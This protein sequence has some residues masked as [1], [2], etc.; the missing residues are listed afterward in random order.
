MAQTDFDWTDSAIARLRELW[1]EGHSTA[2]IGRRMGISKNAI[3]GK[4][5]RLRLKPRPSPVKALTREQRE[6]RDAEMGRRLAA[7]AARKA[8]LPN[9]TGDT[10]SPDAQAN[11][12]R[13]AADAER[14]KRRAVIPRGHNGNFVDVTMNARIE[15]RAKTVPQP[16]RPVPAPLPAHEPKPAS[17][18]PVGRVRP[19]AWI[20]GNT[21]KRDFRTCGEPVEPG[22]PYCLVHCKICYVNYQ[23]K[24][25]LDAGGNP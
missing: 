20:A 16:V 11:R 18:K 9:L 19:C 21:D 10:P 13:V 12:N 17:A 3:V 5:H 4:S 23:P 22:T 15:A 2:E 24:A 7:S 8:T 6:A 1:D 25:A 14:E